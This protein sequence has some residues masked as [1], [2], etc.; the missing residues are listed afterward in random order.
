MKIIST[1]GVSRIENQRITR[2][3][4][5]LVVS[6]TLS[7]LELKDET[8]TIF[9]ESAN[10]NNTEIAT[11]VNLR[12]AMLLS[13][14]GSSL[15][16]GS[17]GTSVLLE[18]A[19]NGAIT[20]GENESIKV[21][22]DNLKTTATYELHGIEMPRPSYDYVQLS[23]KVVLQG[24]VSRKITVANYELA[25]LEGVN[26]VKEIALTYADGTTVKHTLVELQAMAKDID[27]VIATVN[28]DDV[29]NVI[30]SIDDVLLLPVIGVT[31]LDITKVSDKKLNLTLRNTIV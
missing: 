26:D 31:S 17:N 6:S 30:S 21:S 1:T 25:C 13:S 7:I 14:T 8:I 23:E 18:I 4:G 29:L 27:P 28:T 22:L 9:V 16:D 19:F 15:I 5:A 12:R 10:G 2:P 11:N 20:L 24:E 3:I